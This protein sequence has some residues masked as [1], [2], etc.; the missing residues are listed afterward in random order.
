MA[1]CHQLCV[2]ISQCSYHIVLTKHV[3]KIRFAV[4]TCHAKVGVEKEAVKKSQFCFDYVI[5]DDIIAVCL[6]LRYFDVTVC[7]AH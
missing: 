6:K 5:T 4:C 2:N 7:E 3:S 1:H